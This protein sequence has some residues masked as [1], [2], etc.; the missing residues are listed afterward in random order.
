MK[1]I[2]ILILALAICFS[3]VSCTESIGDE[4]VKSADT[5]AESDTEAS[6][7]AKNEAEE[8]DETDEIG[9]SATDCPGS[10]Y[11]N[12]WQE[13]NAMVV[14]WGETNGETWSYPYHE[15]DNGEIY[16]VCTVEYVGVEITILNLFYR[17][18]GL[19][20]SEHYSDDYFSSE[21]EDLTYILIPESYLDS[22]EVGGQALVF[23]DYIYG[24]STPMCC[25][26]GSI[27]VADD[28]TYT[29]DGAPIF[30]VADGIISVPEEMS[31]VYVL[32]Y[33]L[34]D[35]NTFME[36]NYPDV[37]IRF[38]DGMTVE[39]FGEFVEYLCVEEDGLFYP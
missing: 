2:F 21:L 6:G 37:D 28:G 9:Y 30:N 20:R 25:P 32:R 4:D 1:K 5:S 13:M 19:T 23:V 11:P 12:A 22:I 18:A 34:T 7:T 26:L 8:T 3:V 10:I 14:E 39:E 36:K 38:E 16:T 31:E 35:G 17:T 24:S 29:F 33:Y 15:G 27:S